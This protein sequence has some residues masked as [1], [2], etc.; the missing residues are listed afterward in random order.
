M[1]L[2]TE[3]YLQ[4][5]ARLPKSGRHIIAQYDTGTIVVY[6]AYRPSIGHFAAQ[7]GYLGGEDYSLTRMTWI[8]TNFLWMMYRSGWGT[9]EGQE[10]VLAIWLKRAAFQNIL[11]QAVNSTYEPQL[12]P[13][14]EAWQHAVK[15]SE[16]RLQWDPDHH[17][18]GNKLERRAIQLGLRG[19][20]ARQYAQGG[21][22]TEIEDISEFVREQQKQA[23]PP[24]N[25]LIVPRED[26][27]P[28][29][30]EVI[31]RR[32]GLP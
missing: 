31:A 30:D 17:P 23:K 10:I 11:S 24:Y 12:Y 14:R 4:Q 13:T 2:F 15:T 6:Q 20:T 25:E 27:L 22:I 7:H 5:N 29:E 28:V 19:E 18:A 8:K 3:P 9:K 1:K 21:W 16:V 26:I 32:L